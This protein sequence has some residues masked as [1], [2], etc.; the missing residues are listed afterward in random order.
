[1][2]WDPFAWAEF[3]AGRSM[4]ADPIRERN[5]YH[6]KNTYVILEPSN[7]NPHSK[8]PMIPTAQRIAEKGIVVYHWPENASVEKAK[9][10]VYKAP[11]QP[12][13]SRK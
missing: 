6:I 8:L 1:V 7:P 13:I 12:G 3:Y 2:I 9:V 11:P 5:D 10:V 4:Y